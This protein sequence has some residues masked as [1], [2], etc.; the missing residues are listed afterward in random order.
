[1]IDSAINP[2]FIAIFYSSILQEYSFK[3]FESEESAMKFINYMPKPCRV[4]KIERELVK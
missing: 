2:A 1:M 3:Y 4:F